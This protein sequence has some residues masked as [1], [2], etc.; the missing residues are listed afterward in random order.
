VDSYSENENIL[1][2]D[3]LKRH[4]L[5]R[6]KH[7]G[8]AI[9]VAPLTWLILYFFD[10]NITAPTWI[11]EAPLL[12][13]SLILIRPILEELVFRGL[14]QDWLMHKT[15]GHQKIYLLSYA[16]I[17]TSSIFT[18]LHFF[19]HSPWMALLVFA[20]S[21]LFGYFRDR[22]NGWLLPSIMLHCFYNAGYFLLYKPSF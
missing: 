10:N 22:Y 11:I 5:W 3:F 14:L 15:W 20:P 18:C 7:F 12:F 2:T 13:L 4:N 1:K 16:N 19:A 6:D 17:A 9:A 8:A 21:L